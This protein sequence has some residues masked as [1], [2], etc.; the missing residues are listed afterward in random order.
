MFNIIRMIFFILC[1]YVKM[2][3]N[4]IFSYYLNFIFYI[5]FHL[6][7]ISFFTLQICESDQKLNLLVSFVDQHK[8]E[9]HMVFFS[10][11]AGV[12]YF[13]KALQQ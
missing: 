13:S 9:K 12:D 8:D 11:C 3:I 10:T 7:Y 4:I 6:Y 1:R 2:T 5:L